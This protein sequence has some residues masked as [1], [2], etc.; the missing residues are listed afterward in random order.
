MKIRI[1]CSKGFLLMLAILIWLDGEG[2]V[3]C[4]IFAAALH[5]LGH[6][7]MIWLMGGHVQELRLTAIGAEMRL[8]ARYPLDYGKEM[9]AALAGPMV[10]LAAA[11]LSIWREW[12][13]FAGINLCYG[14][15]NLLPIY[16]LDGGRVLSCLL[17]SC[18]P[19]AAERAARWIST[20]FAGALLGLGCAAWLR[21][22]N[23]SLFCTA[24]WIAIGVIKCEI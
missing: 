12:Y 5:E 23:V 13:L 18:A 14:L 11:A 2:L 7:A 17:T 22:G 4:S 19:R 20:A 15:L 16:P 6:G 21:W 3:L 1:H 24:L 10:S 8:D 9:A